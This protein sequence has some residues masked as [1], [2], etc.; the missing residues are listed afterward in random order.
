MNESSSMNYSIARPVTMT[1][2]GL[3]CEHCNVSALSSALSK[4][5]GVT[6]VFI[7]PDS[8]FISLSYHQP[9]FKLAELTKVLERVS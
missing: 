3:S 1:I 6:S 2:R 7:N 4:L 5:P 8:D 9:Q